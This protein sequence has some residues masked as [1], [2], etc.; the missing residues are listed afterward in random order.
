MINPNRP[1]PSLPPAPPPPAHVPPPLAPLAPPMM[2][3][4]TTMVP[5]MTPM[6]PP[7]TLLARFTGQPVRQPWPQPVKAAQSPIWDPLTEL[8]FSVVGTPIAA[9]VGAGIGFL[10]AGPLG[11]AR[12][13]MIG[14][15]LPGSV[16]VGHE[17]IWNSPWWGT[18]QR[19][20]DGKMIAVLAGFPLLSA[21]GYGIGLAVAGAAGAAWG[22]M[23]AAALPIT[24]VM[25]G[26]M[27]ARWLNPPVYDPP[28]TPPPTA[29]TK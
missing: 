24:V 17:L 26:G 1:V 10:V 2:P 18:P 20:T 3:P 19:P 15:A 5:P 23:I 13:A 11:A 27:I 28:L 29:P 4:T 12:G 7:A 8:A 14:A 21:A 9:A 16:F 25:G 22:T 6:T